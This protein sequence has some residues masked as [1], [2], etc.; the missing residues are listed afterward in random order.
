MVQ[1]AL[2]QLNVTD[3]QQQF[4]SQ[5]RIN[6]SGVWQGDAPQQLAACLATQTAFNS[7]FYVD[8]RFQSVPDDKLRQMEPTQARQL[9]QKILQNAAQG[10]GFLYGQ[11]LVDRPA[12]QPT[13]DLLK[14]AYAQIS[15]KDTFAFIE[16][17]TG[18]RNIVYASMQATRYIPGNFLT[19]HNDVVEAEGR[20][21]AYVF[22]LTS[23]WHP[24]WGG[25]LQF[26]T[27]DGKPTQVWTPTINNLVLFEVTQPHAVTYVTPF[28]QFPRYALTG[29]F[30]S[31]GPA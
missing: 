21:I 14:Q 31:K 7:A 22:G 4:Q 2:P 8:N 15:S 28:A 6:I 27:P 23:H 26:F 1:L 9:Q 10:V 19:R 17:V 12:P 16:A 3:L 5:G 25:L 20:L 18:V 30:R 11:H 13:A 24:D 29:W